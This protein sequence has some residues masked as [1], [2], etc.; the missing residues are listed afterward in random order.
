M[1]A[2]EFIDNLKRDRARGVIA[3]HQVV[4]LLS[5][6]NLF[7]EK[8][9]TIFD[10]EELNL[11]FQKVW[12]KYNSKF[13]S[14]SNLVGMPLKALFNQGYIDMD[15]KKSIIDFRNISLLRENIKCVKIKSE[16]ISLFS[17]ENLEDILINRFD[18]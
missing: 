8:N 12:S 9:T 4:L 13:T 11:E 5:F 15:L 3:P 14:K 17:A 6:Y 2:D 10:I 18:K 7:R 16:I 1:K